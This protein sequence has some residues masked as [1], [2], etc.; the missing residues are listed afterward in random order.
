MRYTHTLNGNYLYLP[1]PHGRLGLAKN[2]IN[3]GSTSCT[4]CMHCDNYTIA[5]VDCSHPDKEHKIPE[6]IFPAIL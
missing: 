5:S 4:E 2:P 1:C 3:I 6:E